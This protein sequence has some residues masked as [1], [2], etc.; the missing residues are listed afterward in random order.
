MNSARNDRLAIEEALPEV[1]REWQCRAEWS[2]AWRDYALLMS[3]FTE[4][5][6]RAPLT[7]DACE[8]VDPTMALNRELAYLSDV[9]RVLF[10]GGIIGTKSYGTSGSVEPIEPIRFQEKSEAQPFLHPQDG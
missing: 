3:A 9:L 7:L 1:F 10:P 8:T 5:L 4:A 2:L 6:W